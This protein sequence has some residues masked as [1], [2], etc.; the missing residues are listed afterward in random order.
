MMNQITDLEAFEIDQVDGG[1][2]PAVIVWG[3]LEGAAY[4]AATYAAYKTIAG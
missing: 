1:I 4:G 3:I 2:L